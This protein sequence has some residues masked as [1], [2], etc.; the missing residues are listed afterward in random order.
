MT[1]TANYN[2]NII[3]GSDIVN[4]LTD[5]AP[6]FEIIDEEMFKNKNAGIGTATELLSGTVHTL[7]R[8]NPNG[9]MFR[10][11]ATAKYTSGET[12]AVDGVQVT[13]LLPTGETLPTGAYVIGSTV[14]C[15]LVGT[16]L[17]I[18]ATGSNATTLEQHPASYFA[19]ADE[20]GAVKATANASST[21]ATAN[22][23]A[24]DNLETSII[25]QQYTQEITVP[26]NSVSTYSFN[27]F[28]APETA[29]RLG[30]ITLVCGS[31]HVDVAPTTTSGS[32]K[33]RN[34]A[35][36]EKTVMV[37]GTYLWGNLF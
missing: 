22:S 6:N 36:S 31:S 29:R 9:A 30:A 10:F 3:E 25:R 12:F 2:L 15:C 34:Y 5:T 28:E 24:I 21:L 4:P 19:T 7:T 14:L 16:V 13:A 18:F 33:I 23:K 1:K 27:D 17:T 26:A 37:T 35:T 20:L 11:I 32:F 8:E